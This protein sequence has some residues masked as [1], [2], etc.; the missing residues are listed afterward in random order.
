[1][2]QGGIRLV[3]ML[4]ELGGI[5]CEMTITR[6]GPE[7]FY[8][9]SAIMGQSHDRDWL[10]QHVAGDDDVTVNDVTDETALLGLSGPRTRD[11]LAPLTAADLGNES[12]R[13]LTAQEI[14]VA[15]VPVKA[16][17]VSYVGELGWEL[18][19]PIDRMAELYEAICEAGEPH[20]M[21][22]Y[23]SYAM[24][25]MR[26]EKAYKAWG[27]ELTTEITP[28]EARIERFVDF[29]KDFVGK[30]AT[31][32]RRDGPEPLQWALVYCSVDEGDNDAWGN[33]PAYAPGGEDIMGIATSGAYGHSVGTSLAFVYV[34]P[35]FEAPGSMFELEMLGERRTATVLPAAA[36][37]PQNRAPRT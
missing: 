35:E 31:L 22:H 29:S 32:A 23:G 12:F 36:Y 37:D 24:N 3:H 25:V 1:P 5:E 33:E 11:V 19:C 27:V 6:L 20:D 13:W 30:E 18:H 7:R 2:G 21:V 34:A 8:L 26:I 28:I 17:R 4:T 14:E 16:L 9:S 15:G 10:T